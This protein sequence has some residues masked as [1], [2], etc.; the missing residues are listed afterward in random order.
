MS[1]YITTHDS[2]GYARFCTTVPE[3]QHRMDVPMTGGNM[4]II[5]TT[6][7]FPAKVST[8]D[9]IETY[10][11][12]RVNGLPAANPICPPHGVAA[13]IISIA[14][15]AVLPMHRTMTLDIVLSLKA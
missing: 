3:K 2:N 8:E 15:N 13:A 9:D 10:A 12:D 5:Y 1:T 14:P 4:K 7:S 6:H 11:H